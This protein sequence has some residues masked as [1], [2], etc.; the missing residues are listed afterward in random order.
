MSTQAIELGAFARLARA[1]TVL[2]RELEAEVLTPR[3]LTFNDFEALFHL[4]RADDRRLRRVDLAGLVMLT[5]SGV[6]RLLEGLQVAGFVENRQCDDDARV[7]WA[8][9]T[10]EGA[11]TI[12]CVGAEH[13]EVLRG[14]FRG[15]LDDDEVAQ[16]AALLEKLPGVGAGS[17]AG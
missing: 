4:Y 3:G 6:T 14:F 8:A 5:P 10:A 11:R 9:L 15:A 17:C 2:R 12:E 7:T 13:T 1:H 16:L